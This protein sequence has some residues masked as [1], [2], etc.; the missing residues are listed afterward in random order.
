VQA[1]MFAFSTGFRQRFNAVATTIQLIGTIGL[2][3]LLFA[4]DD[5]NN[6]LDLSNLTSTGTVSSKGYYGFGELTKVGPWI[7]G[8]LLGAVTIVGL[9][10]RRPPRNPRAG[11]HRA[12]G[13]VA[14]GAQAS[15][16]SCSSSPLPPLAAIRRRSASSTAPIA[17]VISR[18]LG[19]VVGSIL[20]VLVVI[21]TGSC[22]LV[23]LLSGTR[24]VWAMSRDA[25][26]PG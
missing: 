16:A 22:G 11:A 19:P 17:D 18:V 14:G 9:R 4:V 24:P 3:V 15:S 8:T 23:I 7:R 25:R 26:F 12:E 6:E 1:V 2:V 5:I 10:I 20:L 21:S 13:R